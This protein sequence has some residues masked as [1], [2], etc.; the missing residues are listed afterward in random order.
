[1]EKEKKFIKPEC[2]IIILHMDDIIT[3]SVNFPGKIDE[4]NT[5]D[6]PLM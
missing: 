3:D 2:E 6:T 5:N 1:M 4:G